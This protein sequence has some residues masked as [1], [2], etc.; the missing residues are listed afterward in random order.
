[1]TD[2][3]LVRSLVAPPREFVEP[4]ARLQPGQALDWAFESEAPIA[5]NTHFHDSSAVKYQEHISAIMAAK[6]R[7]ASSTS[8]DY[9]WLWS[10]PSADAANIRMWITP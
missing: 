8:H 2:R 10:N 6:V 7:L 3:A 9:C 5:F 1:M 4:C